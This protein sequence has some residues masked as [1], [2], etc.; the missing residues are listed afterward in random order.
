[1][2]FKFLQ[3]KTSP[4]SGLLDLLN[5]NV[6]GTPGL[7]MLYQHRSVADKIGKITNPFFVNLV[8]NTHIIGTCCFCKRTT[9][10][11]GKQNPAFYIRYFSFKDVFRRK[12]VTVKKSAVRSA[13][14]QEVNK[15]LEGDGLEIRQSEKFYHYAY[16][17][18]R[19]V[20]SASLCADFGFETVRE[21]STVIFSRLS[22]KGTAIKM[23]QVSP[24]EEYT[25]K[26]LVSEFYKDFNMFCTEN[27]FNGR[28]YYV[29][30]DE[31]NRILAGC[32]AN[33]DQ[34]RILSL[35]GLSG[36]LIL[37]VFSSLPMLRKLISKD[38]RFI[39][40]EGTYHAPGFEHLLEELFENLLHLYHVNS[41]ITVVDADTKLYRTLRSLRL[42]A[43]DRLNKEV[44]GNVICRFFNFSNEE[45]KEFT[46]SP[47]YISGIDVT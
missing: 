12:S 18:P 30:K 23:V 44:R 3:V 16:V 17:D 39:S 24:E 33:P 41:A 10:D 2:I 6:I 34:W 26:T 38:Y 15:V 4:D 21:Y 29:I 14:R 27:L 19:N 31:Q 13:L 9:S 45:K 32:Q 37:N 28:K 40:V 25:V 43:V 8:K 22:P 42:G 5:R 35:P 1:M 47:A 7:G 11:S 36:T 46:T 20:R